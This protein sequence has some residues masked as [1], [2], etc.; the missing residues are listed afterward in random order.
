[1]PSCDGIANLIK[2]A[3]GLSP[4]VNY[5]GSAALPY[6]QR[7]AVS[8]T[9]YLTLTFTRNA[10]ATDV[11]YSVEATSDLT[12]TWTSIDPLNAAN[13]TS[14]L[15]DTPSPGI[16]TITVKDAQPASSSPRRFMRLRVT[17]P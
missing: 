13:Q 10:Q 14:V 9:T 8:G 3:L 15:S 7:Q 11:T 1:M 4:K 17:V 6:A 5:S 2:Y 16:Q 12:A